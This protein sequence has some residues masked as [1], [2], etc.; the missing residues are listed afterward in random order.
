MSAGALAGNLPLELG[1][2][3]A[4]DNDMFQLVLRCYFISFN[5][6]C[7]FMFLLDEN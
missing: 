2:K 5:L 3:R 4:A 1:K 6:P 7:D